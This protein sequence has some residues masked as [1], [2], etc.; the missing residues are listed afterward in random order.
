V[1]CLR[2]AYIKTVNSCVLT[3]CV[4]PPP[5]VWSHKD[6]TLQRALNEGV[7]MDEEMCMSVSEMI[8]FGQ[9]NMFFRWKSK[10]KTCLPFFV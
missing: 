3:H 9:D 1:R 2:V 8:L 5:K 6:L 7:G 4:A 10:R